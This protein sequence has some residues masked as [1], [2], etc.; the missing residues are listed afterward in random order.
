MP[1]ALDPKIITFLKEHHVSTLATCQSNKPWCASVFYAVWEEEAFLIFTS[2]VATRHITQGLA[3]ARVAGAIAL[4]TETIGLIRGLQ[5]SGWLREPSPSQKRKALKI[6][7]K[8]FPYA[9]L[10]SAPLWLLELSEAKFTDNRLGFGKK[11]LWVREN[12]G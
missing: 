9:I 11:L 3:Q 2:E 1:N 6:Y 7:L 5:Y 8:R 4:E 10:H 12:E